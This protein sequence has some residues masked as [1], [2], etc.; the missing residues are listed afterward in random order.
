MMNIEKI[1]EDFPIL[2][3]KINNHP[4]VYL[5]NAATTQKPASVIR[6]LAHYYEH[7]N[8]NIHRAVHHLG[9]EATQAYENSRK[10]VAAWIN[11]PDY[12]TV[13][14]TRN[15]TEAINLVAF[16]WGRKFLSPGDEILLTELEHHSNLVPWHVLKEEKQI[17]LKFIPFDGQG[18]LELS[19]LSHLITPKT[20]LV[21]FCQMS[22]ALGTIVPAKEIIDKAHEAGALVLVDGAQSVPHM[23]V[24]VQELD[25]DFLAFSSHK[26]LGPTGIG[27]LYGKRDILESMPPFLGGGEMIREVWLDHSTYNK[28]PWKY[29]AGTPNIA[30]AIAFG[31]A[32]DYLSRL[33]MQAIR[34]H[35]IEITR[36]AL[37][38]FSELPRVTVYGPKRPEERGGIISFNLEEIHP[39]D[40][41]TILDQDGVAIRAGHHCAQP[42]MRKLGVAGTARASFYI[43]NTCQEIDR[44]ISSIHHVFEVFDRVAAR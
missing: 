43:Y 32:I 14:F 36:Y 9:E 11:A 41:G 44:L 26:M 5:D 17:V 40:V 34:N 6:A 29:E 25:C 30:D 27:V 21:S 37:E 28:I 38:K 22:N 23:S 15:C 19:Q 2:K 13:L 1:R 33:G 3:R 39:H 31:E 18:C 42:V 12:H 16:S 10:K 7:F 4:L 24:D 20:K 8:A 35:Q